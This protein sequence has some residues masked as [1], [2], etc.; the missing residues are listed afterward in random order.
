MARFCTSR[1][2]EALLK[3][4]VSQEPFCFSSPCPL[5]HVI[6]GKNARSWAGTAWGVS[7][8][9]GKDGNVVVH[10]YLLHCSRASDRGGEAA[11][12]PL[13]KTMGHF[14]RN[15]QSSE[16]PVCAVPSA[17]AF[18]ARLPAQAHPRETEQE[19]V[20]GSRWKVTPKPRQT[21]AEVAREFL[22]V[23]LPDA[24]TAGWGN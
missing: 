24:T 11:W 1:T 16:P 2:R 12:H 14:H 18:E 19:L 8:S 20:L 17:E 23:C 21:R 15:V 3:G 5:L 6:Q 22:R 10:D 4:S 13:T 9:D 7:V